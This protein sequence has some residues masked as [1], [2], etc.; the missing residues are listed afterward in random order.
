MTMTKK[1]TSPSYLVA[2]KPLNI[3][4]LWGWV[5]IDDVTSLSGNGLRVLVVKRM[6][7]ARWKTRRTVSVADI[8]ALFRWSRSK[9]YRALLE[10]ADRP[11]PIQ[12]LIPASGT[13]I[14]ASGTKCPADPYEHWRFCAPR[15]G[16]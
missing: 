2:A 15:G 5:C 14:P 11:L 7:W 16:F 9:A 4:G 8:R 10:I 12:F 1:R 13:V 3:T 6:I